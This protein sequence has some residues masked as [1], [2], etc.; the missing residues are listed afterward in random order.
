MQKN[1]LQKEKKF[2]RA[3]INLGR[4]MLQKVNGIRLSQFWKNPAHLEIQMY[5]QKRSLNE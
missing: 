2:Q 1:L 5:L 4:F 3:I